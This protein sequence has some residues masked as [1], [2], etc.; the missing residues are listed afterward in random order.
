[1]RMWSL[2][3]TVPMPRCSFEANSVIQS[4]PMPSSTVKV[5]RPMTTTNSTGSDERADFLSSLSIEDAIALTGADTTRSIAPAGPDVARVEMAKS[6]GAQLA[7]QMI[8]RSQGV[9][10]VTLNPEELG[11][12]KMA[13]NA[14]E[15]TV[16][17]SIMAERPETLDLMR[18]HIDQL[19]EEFQQMGFEGIELAF[20]DGAAAQDDTSDT[21]SSTGAW[22][23]SEATEMALETPDEIPNRPGQQSGLDMRL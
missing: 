8:K 12:V 20:S 23:S 10:D 2:A 11:R 17:I 7:E 13:V 22:G 4:M 6:V 1:M 14:G 19:I 5:P 15:S 21:P 9:V 3:V 16:S 18:R